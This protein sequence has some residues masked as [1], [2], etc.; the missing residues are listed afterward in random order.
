VN[1]LLYLNP[2]WTEPSGGSLE[3][4]SNPRN[5]QKN[6]MVLIPP[7]ANRLVIFETNEISWHGHG[8]I[9]LFPR[10]SVAVYFYT[11]AD[12]EASPP[13]P[14]STVYSD[15]AL[16]GAES[17]EEVTLA[18]AKRQSHLRRQ[19]EAERE[20]LGTLC[21]FSEHAIPLL[22]KAESHSESMADT[23]S[24]LDA[25]I[26]ASYEREKLLQRMIDERS[27]EALA[28]RFLF[29]SKTKPEK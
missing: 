7:V 4:H 23:I 3:L 10:R 20:L 27:L 13:L 25:Q 9:A 14:H 21:K 28:L 11:D 15:R 8:K 26:T 2:E 24:A 12:L 5:L 22:E 29:D 6:E 16:T 1:V 18:L 17:A 19:I